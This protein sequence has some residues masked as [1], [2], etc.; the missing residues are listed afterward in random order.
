MSD[1]AASTGSTSINI[2]IFGAPHSKSDFGEVL[3]G[4]SKIKVG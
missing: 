1:L 2:G 4:E 3:G